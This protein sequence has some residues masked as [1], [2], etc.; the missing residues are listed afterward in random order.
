MQIRASNTRSRDA[1]N[2]IRSAY[3]RKLQVAYPSPRITLCNTHDQTTPPLVYEFINKYTYGKGV[4]RPDPKKVIG[5]GQIKQ[6]G[7]PQICR[8]EM[9]G[10]CGC[11]Y[12]KVCECLQFARLARDDDQED[13]E[14]GKLA[15]TMGL[16]KKFPYSKETKLLVHHY[17]MSSWPIYECNDNCACGPICKSRVVQLGRQVRLE[18]FRTPPAQGRG[19]GLRAKEHLKR[20]QFIDCYLGE[21]I[22]NA[23]VQQRLQG[24][25][26]AKPSYLFDLDCHRKELEQAG[27]GEDQLYTV[28][29]EHTGNA[30]RFINHSCDPN[31]AVY[32]VQFDKNNNFI[33]SLAFFA[34][35]DIPKDTELTFDYVNSNGNQEED[36]I[37]EDSI[38]CRCG[39][40]NCR[41]WLWR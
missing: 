24:A 41:K 32:T 4:I 18:I 39:A 17:I 2:H 40:K 12:T 22:T 21:V 1:N 10:H 13:F 30:T 20:G 29:G 19:W 38:P 7:N 33:Y 23:T 35:E 5:C 36:E 11:E 28:D 6:P 14:N 9:G 8:P 27:I 25:G 15:T 31:C 37:D 16:P 3:I 34:T 26:K